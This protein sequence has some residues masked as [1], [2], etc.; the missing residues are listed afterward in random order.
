MRKI[1]KIVLILFVVGMIAGCGNAQRKEPDEKKIVYAI[2]SVPEYIR[3][4]ADMKELAKCS[5]LVIYGEVTSYTCQ[6]IGGYAY[7]F[8][9]VRVNEVLQG[10]AAV[11]DTVTIIK[12][13]GTITIEEYISTLSD[14]RR[15]TE[16]E[17]FA[18]YSEEEKSKLYIRFES[19]QDIESEVGQKSVYFICKVPEFDRYHAYYRLNDGRG[20]YLETDEGEFTNVRSVAGKREEIEAYSESGNAIDEEVC[21]TPT[22]TMESIQKEMRE[23][24][25]MADIISR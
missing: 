11:G 18:S 13:I 23:G 24:A 25:D 17:R 7:T 16:E 19:Y 22:Y 2:S 5:E 15:E 4:Y 12:D 20:Q 6:A 3:G 10:D 14:D 1:S 8:E 9:D 21:E